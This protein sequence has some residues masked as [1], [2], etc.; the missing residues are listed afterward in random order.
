M[1][2][3]R[4]VSSYLRRTYRD[5]RDSGRSLCPEAFCLD[6]RKACFTTPALRHCRGLPKEAV[7]SP[8]LDI[9]KTR[10]INSMQP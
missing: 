2:N 8:S 10:F 1:E 3:L 9:F 5:R 7:R 4:A 6:M